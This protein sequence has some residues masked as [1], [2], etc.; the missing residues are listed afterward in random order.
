MLM[1]TML[2]LVLAAGAPSADA[3]TPRQQ[4]VP[5]SPTGTANA[6]QNPASRRNNPALTVRCFVA[7]CPR[8]NAFN[9]YICAQCATGYQLTA[10]LACNSC[11]RGYEQNLDAQTFTCS[12]CPAG[13][14]SPGGTGE[15]S[16]CSAIT[17]T[18][19]RRLFER[20]DAEDL[21]A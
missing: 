1:A 7:N 9:P 6:Q 3:Q 4:N 12:A 20:T 21:W 5:R 18:S 17:T 19:G 16:Q 14:D 8:C 15:A 2:L 13:F 10:A 11:A